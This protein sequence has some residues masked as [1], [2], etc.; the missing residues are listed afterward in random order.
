MLNDISTTLKVNFCFLESSAPVDDD[1]DVRIPIALVEEVNNRFKNSL[2]GYFIGKKMHDVPLAAYTFGDLSMIVT[3]LS[4]HMML[5]SYT[6]NMC[7]DLWGRNN[8]DREMIEISANMDLVETLMVVVSKLEEIGYTKEIIRLDYEWKSPRC[9]TCSIF[10]YLTHTRP[11]S[12]KEP[13]KKGVHRPS[14]GPNSDGF[15]VV[16]RMNAKRKQ[17]SKQHTTQFT[18]LKLQ[19]SKSQLVFRPKAKCYCVESVSFHC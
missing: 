8:Y 18:S 3:K 7:L 17:G 6:S 13:S 9:G 5:D 14:D 2:Y 16:K 1:F 10:G 11:N 4:K 12:T 15:V 19:K